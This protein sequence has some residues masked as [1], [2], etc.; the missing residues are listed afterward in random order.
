MH[1]MLR[2]LGSVYAL[3]ALT[4][5]ALCRGL[6]VAGLVSLQHRLMLYGDRCMVLWVYKIECSPV[7]ADSLYCSAI[8]AEG[9]RRTSK[10]NSRLMLDTASYVMLPSGMRPLQHAAYIC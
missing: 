9:C 6:T 5:A 4:K 2:Q 7:S 10:L 3:A 1:D 8:S